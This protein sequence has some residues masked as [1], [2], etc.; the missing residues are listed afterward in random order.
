MSWKP[1]MSLMSKVTLLKVTAPHPGA[2]DNSGAAAETPV[3][4]TW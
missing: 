1:P 4:F 2:R 3:N